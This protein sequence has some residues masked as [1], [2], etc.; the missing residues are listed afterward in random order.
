MQVC[1]CV[2]CEHFH[3]IKFENKT[4][5]ILIMLY[6]QHFRIFT[7]PLK[8]AIAASASSFEEKETNA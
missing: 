4:N 7:W 1:A 2:V 8:V 3:A 6:I 5:N